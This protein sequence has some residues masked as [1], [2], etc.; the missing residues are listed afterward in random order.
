MAGRDALAARDRGIDLA[1][2][3]VTVADVLTRYLRDR[4]GRC[5]A[6]TLQEYEK[7]ANRYIIPHL[8]AKAL[9]KL[10]PAHI[11]EWQQTLAERGGD[12]G[13]ALSAKTTFHARSLLS[14]SLR[15]ACKM[16]LLVVNPCTAV[17]APIVRRSDAK[18]LTRDEIGRLLKATSNPGRSSRLQDRSRALRADSLPPPAP[19][20]FRAATR[21]Q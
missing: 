11:A 7:I 2:A 6:K 14:A 4:K 16:Q 8:G 17:D 18:A 9:A 3:K 5:A 10:R 19:S 1:P 15:W 21:A 13:R 20:R 12:E